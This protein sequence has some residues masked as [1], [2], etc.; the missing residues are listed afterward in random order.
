MFIDSW[1]LSH[2][3]LP[4]S[5]PIFKT[6]HDDDMAYTMCTHILDWD[7]HGVITNS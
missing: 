7:L 6:L 2:K 4:D 1:W 3:S 5:V